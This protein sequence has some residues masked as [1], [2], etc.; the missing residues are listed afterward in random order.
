VSEIDRLGLTPAPPLEH[1]P[2]TPG[3][4]LS[5]LTQAVGRGRAGVGESARSLSCHLLS[6]LRVFGWTLLLCVGVGALLIQVIQSSQ[7]GTDF[8]QD[9]FAAQRLLQGE[10]PYLPLR[11]A[12][13]ASLCPELGLYDSH[14]P[15]SVLLFLPLGL[16]SQMFAACIWGCISMAAYLLSGLLLLRELGWR[17]Q[18]GMALFVLA[19]LFWTPA[20]LAIGSHNLGQ[21]V[22]VLVVGAWVLERKQRIGWAGVVVGVAGLLKLWPVVL[23]VNALIWRKPRYALVGALTLL[24]GMALSL[25]LPGPAAYAAYLGPVQEEERLGVPAYSNT[26]VI[27]DVARLFIGYP[28]HP[29]M[30]PL[31]QG[32]SLAQAVMLAEG[33]G[34]LLLGATL[35]FLWWC[36]RRVEPETGFLLSQGLLVVVL[37][38]VFPLTWYWGLVTLLLPAATTLLALRQLPRPPYWWWAILLASLVLLL[39]PGGILVGIPG[40]LLASQNTWLARLANPLTWLPTCGLLLFAVVQAQ[41]LWRASAAPLHDDQRIPAALERGVAALG[42]HDDT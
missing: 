32:L 14:P 26:S 34:G 16:F 1:E 28:A 29:P 10:A 2:Q 18:R 4:E 40:W 36:R 22:T 42:G 27:G 35:V 24:G 25:L 5:P 33:I 38:L 39:I 8:C 12:T 20:I 31:I 7:G 41:L 17:L 6:F 21:A 3:R 19:S 15:F 30:P 11:T 37:L 23:L 9:F 13:G